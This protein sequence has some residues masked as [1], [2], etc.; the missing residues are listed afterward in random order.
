MTKQIVLED[1]EI[2]VEDPIDQ[3]DMAIDKTN[4]IESEDLSAEETEIL[5]AE[6]K[7][8]DQAKAKRTNLLRISMANL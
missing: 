5:T 6:E 7:L 8:P 2:S 3:I 1:P 4:P